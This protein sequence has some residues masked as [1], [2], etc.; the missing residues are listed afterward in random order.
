MRKWNFVLAASVCLLAVGCANN[1]GKQ[2]VGGNYDFEPDVAGDLDKAKQIFYALPSPI[3]TAYLIHSTGVAY[4]MDLSNSVDKV[5]NYATTMQKALNFGVYGADLSYVSLFNQ[6]QAS[7][8][9]MSAVK[10]LAD[11]MG[12]FDFVQ[13]DIVNRIESNINDR[14]SLMEIITDGFNSANDYLKD[15]GR[16]EVVAL[17]V[18]GGWIEGLYLA[19]SLAQTANDNTRLIDLV[20][21]QRYSLSIL[22]K[23]LDNYKKSSNVSMVYGWFADLQAT[24]GRIKTMSSDIKAETTT[25]GKTKLAADTDIFIND[26]LFNAICQKAD[27]IRTLIVK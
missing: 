12:I 7:I 27:S 8:Q 26:M 19:T 16:A 3:E 5:P 25:D 13:A 18:A 10:S 6:T 4:S 9:Y 17:I 24:Y 23:L 15:A 11:D 20:I 21:D 22:M 1:E 2:K 14:D